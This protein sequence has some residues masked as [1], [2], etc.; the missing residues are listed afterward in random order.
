[1]IFNKQ[2]MLVNEFDN[3]EEVEALVM[4]S[5]MLDYYSSEELETI[6]EN[7]YDINRAVNEELL[8]ERSIVRLDK[9]AK[10]K[11][12]EKMAVFQ[13]AKQKGDRDFKKLMTLWKLERFI[14]A[15][16]A[17]R[18]SAQAKTL[19]KETMKRAAK[20]KSKA[21]GGAVTKAKNLLN[22]NK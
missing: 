21:L 9:A 13:V 20:T 15:K 10:K 3:Q 8:L 12:A 22:A 11:K 18:Y 7:S 16:L 1:M 2:G 5:V 17:K 4:E 14:E 19:A 6:L